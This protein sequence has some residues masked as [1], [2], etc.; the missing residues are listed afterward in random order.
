MDP[1]APLPVEDVFEG[2]L[3][4]LLVMG[5]RRVG[6]VIEMAPS[7]GAQVSQDSRDKCASREHKSG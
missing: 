4:A 1:T 6:G 5:Q 7:R 3:N 2:S